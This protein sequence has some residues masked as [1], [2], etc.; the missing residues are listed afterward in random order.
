[1]FGIFELWLILWLLKN[2]AMDVSYAVKGGANPRYELKKAKARAAGQNPPSQPRYGTRDWFTDL[3]ADGLEA[4][5]EHRRRKA[6]AKRKARELAE[7][8][9]A[10]LAA[11]PAGGPAGRPA[12]EPV[13]KPGARPV[14][15]RQGPAAPVDDDVIDMKTS[16]ACSRTDC[17]R[18]AIQQ[19]R[20]WPGRPDSSPYAD[21]RCNRC[22][23]L[24]EHGGPPPADVARPGAQTS[25]PGAG[26]APGPEQQQ[27]PRP[28]PAP[29]NRPDAKVIPFRTT[30]QQEEPVSTDVNSEVVGLDQ[31]IAYAHSLA[32]FAGEHGQAGNE[33]YI[34]H[35]TGQ[36]VAGDALRTA[37]EMQEAFTNAQAAAEAHKAELEKQKAVQEQ[38]DAN[39]DAGD[40]DYQT[41]GR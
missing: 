7:A 35:L 11:G 4:Q 34:G 12:G 16:T 13:P 40:K 32:T 28:T 6:G 5:T 23:W 18:G 36:K 2:A 15:D 37:A 3:L 10:E 8:E 9:E 25:E 38:Y 17:P 21:Q 22:G 14:D 29:D 39:P 24:S 1:M 26:G 41:E 30:N 20:Q 31:S 19:Y 33:G 27:P